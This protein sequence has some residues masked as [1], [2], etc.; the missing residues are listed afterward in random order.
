MGCFGFAYA[1]VPPILLPISS[2]FNITETEA[3]LIAAAMFIGAAVFAFPWGVIA[4][5]WGLRKAVALC[6]ILLLIEWIVSF[7]STNLG[8]FFIG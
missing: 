6:Q 2:H 4:D 8:M 7:V 3:S 1:V 5:R